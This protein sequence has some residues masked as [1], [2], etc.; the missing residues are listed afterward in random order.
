MFVVANQPNLPPHPPAKHYLLRQNS[1]R[2]RSASASPR[3][4]NRPIPA[5]PSPAFPQP[6]LKQSPPST[7]SPAHSRP[8]SPELVFEPSSASSPVNGGDRRSRSR[9]AKKGARGK[10]KK[11]VLEE[12]FDAL[13]LGPSE[14]DVWEMPVKGNGR[15]VLTWQ[16]TSIG[17]PSKPAPSPRPRSNKP[18]PAPSTAKSVMPFVRTTKPSPS[19]AYS[20]SRAPKSN[21]TWQQALFEPSYPPNPRRNLQR[22]ASLE[23]ELGASYSSS[24]SWPTDQS[25]GG[26]S[27]RPLNH[28]Q[29]SPLKGPRQEESIGGNTYAGG[30][31]QNAPSAVD[32]PK[33]RFGGRA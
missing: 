7:S 25:T 12:A 9:T 18:Y 6:N 32:L 11:L 1:H 5:S 3:P 23:S 4:R 21:L 26:F 19:T 27:H 22:R 20:P 16:Q 13:D 2:S 10:E 14:A 17:S 24:P 30:T 8:P 29:G 28:H 15:D 31:F 33:P